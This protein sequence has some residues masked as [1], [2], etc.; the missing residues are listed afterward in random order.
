M[1]FGE[2]SINSA[3]PK[4]IVWVAA[5]S[6]AAS[7]LRPSVRP[8]AAVRPSTVGWIW[9]CVVVVVQSKTAAKIDGGRSDGWT[10]GRVT[11]GRTLF[12]FC[13]NCETE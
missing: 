6:K 8:F 5:A 3:E 1:L 10:D 2:G 9:Q 12:W 13:V 7:V 4:D 11:N